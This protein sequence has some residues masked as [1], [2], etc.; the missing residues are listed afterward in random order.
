MVFILVDE[1]LD[2]LIS[3][4]AKFLWSIEVSL[5][6]ES[7][8]DDGLFGATLMGARLMGAGLMG[9]GLMSAGLVDTESMYGVWEIEDVLH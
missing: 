3:D 9:A 4:V 8:H 6:A 5:T 2:S 7:T 1:H